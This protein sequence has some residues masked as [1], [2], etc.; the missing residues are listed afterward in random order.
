MR[1]LLLLR[2]AKSGWDDPQLGDHERP[3]AKRGARDAARIGDYLAKHDLV[4]D[5]V[6]CSDAVRTRATLTIVLSRVEGA[7]PRIV[8][9]RRLYL[10]EPDAI[11]AA[12]AEVD[13]ATDRVMVI[14]HNPGMHALALGLTGSG[15]GKALAQLALK[16]PTA[17]LAVIDFDADGW[18]RLAAG[19]GTL[20]AFVTPKGL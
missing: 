6:L 5:L 15:A 13:A 16:Y 3:L 11:V 12:L 9:D 19:K 4:P 2:H 8:Y 18:D 7:A 10:A 20:R 14:G 17:G 1:T